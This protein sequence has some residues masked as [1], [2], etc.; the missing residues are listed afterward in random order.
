MKHRISTFLL[1]PMYRFIYL[2]AVSLEICF[3]FQMRIQINN[4]TNQIIHFAALMT[5]EKEN[6]QANGIEL[7]LKMEK[8]QRIENCEENAK[9]NIVLTMRTMTTT[10]MAIKTATVRIT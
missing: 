8:K 3:A 2:F 7:S 6:A 9:K 4:Q 1:E 5:N 10:T